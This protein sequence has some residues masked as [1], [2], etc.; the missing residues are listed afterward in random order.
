MLAVLS[1]G[2]SVSAECG[3]VLW[4]DETTLNSS[5]RT[6]EAS[7]PGGKSSIKSAQSW[8]II[9]AYPTHAECEK[10]Q[11]LKIA[12]MLR[13]WRKDKAQAQ[14]GEHTV[15]HEAGTNSI[16]KDSKYIGEFTT[17]HWMS[18]RYLCLPSTVDPR[19]PSQK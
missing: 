10:S 6:S 16:S 17:S 4:W 15:S 12:A 8:G 13:S 3:W 2:Q 14:F 18:I 1:F 5:Y 9:G 7:V 11:E 19:G